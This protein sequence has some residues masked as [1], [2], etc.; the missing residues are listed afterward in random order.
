MSKN[1]FRFARCLV[2]SICVLPVLVAQSVTSYGDGVELSEAKV[3]FWKAQSQTAI[4]YLLGSIHIGKPEFYPMRA[5][6]EEA[7]ASAKKLAVESDVREDGNPAVLKKMIRMAMLPEGETLR[8]VLHKETLSLLDKY[9]EDAHPVLGHMI[10]GMRPWVAA[11]VIM[12][13]EAEKYGYDLEHGVDM[14]FMK[15]AV[16]REMAI[17]E[18]EDPMWLAKL[19]DD[20]QDLMLRQILKDVGDAEEAIEK[21]I[22]IW[23]KG[24]ADAL[25]SG[26]QESYESDEWKPLKEIMLTKRDAEMA[27]KVKEF[28]EGE[29]TVFVVVGAAHLVGDGS[30]ISRLEE[31]EQTTVIRK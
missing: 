31:M 1:V 26:V 21:L 17:V 7:F 8:D 16:E 24:D 13:M 29:E 30:I 12:V 20:L 11:S 23:R 9:L 18:L 19:D 10:N 14:Y 3:F 28:L 15:K 4:V 6:I 5:E 2:L 22:D 27:G 25:V